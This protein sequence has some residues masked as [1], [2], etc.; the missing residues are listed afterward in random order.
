MILATYATAVERAFE[1]LGPG[2]L[3]RYLATTGPYPVERVEATLVKDEIPAGNPARVVR[4]D[5]R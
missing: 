1:E 3:E 4:R 2:E 5:G